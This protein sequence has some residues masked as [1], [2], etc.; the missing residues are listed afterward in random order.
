MGIKIA[1]RF[2]MYIKKEFRVLQKQKKCYNFAIETKE[3]VYTY[4]NLYEITTN[5]IP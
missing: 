5:L 3:T 4:C 1:I 2:L